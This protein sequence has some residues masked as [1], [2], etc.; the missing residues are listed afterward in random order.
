MRLKMRRLV[1]DPHFDYGY[2]PNSNC[3]SNDQMAAEGI[4]KWEAPLTYDKNQCEENKTLVEKQNFT[5]SSG[6]AGGKPA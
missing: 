4:P 2:D 3:P 5:I 6:I 1:L